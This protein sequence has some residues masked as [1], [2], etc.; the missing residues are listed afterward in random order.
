MSIWK[1]IH[2]FE[3]LYQISDTGC[4]KSLERYIN[5]NGGKLLVK[6]CILKPGLNRYGYLR[7]A[8]RINSQKKDLYAHQLVAIHFIANPN[9]RKIV[10]HKDGNK[11]NNDVSNLEWVTCRENAE[12]ALKTGLRHKGIDVIRKFRTGKRINDDIRKAIK[13]LADDGKL[14]REIAAIY[15]IS[16][17]YVSMIIRNRA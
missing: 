13:K 8:L 7:Y 14:L 10:N 1:D 9:N 11:L 2:G 3:G 16:L 5:L 6:E 17:G 4:V 12:H 15:N